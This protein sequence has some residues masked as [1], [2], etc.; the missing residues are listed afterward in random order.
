MNCQIT[1]ARLLALLDYDVDTGVFVWRVTRG[2]CAAG[3]VAGRLNQGYIRI[4]LD[5]IEYAAHRLAWF[6]CFGEW[7]REDIDH[8]YADTCDNRIGYL[9]DVSK[10]MNQ[11]NRRRAAINSSTGYIGVTQKGDGFV[12]QI[13]VDGK[14]LTFGKHSTPLA[15]HLAYVDAKRVLHPGNT[16]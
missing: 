7:P 4:K 8:L 9:R 2:R 12:A 3:D 14:H 13:G 1:H 11:Q 15:A 10:S 16:L 6:W 5:G